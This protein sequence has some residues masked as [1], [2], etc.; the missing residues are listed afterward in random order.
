MIN[1]DLLKCDA[2]E[3]VADFL[4]IVYS[5]N[6][7]PNITSPTRLTSRSHTL[8]HKNFSR[9]INDDC[10][11]GNLVSPISDHHVKFLIIPNYTT[12]QNSKNDFYK[13]NFRHFCFKNFITDLQKVKWDNILN[14][15]VDNVNKS[16]QNI[17]NK[18]TDILDKHASITRLFPKVMES[19]NKSWLTK[20]NLKFI[21]T[22]N[23][24]SKE[25]YHLEFKRYKRM[26][27]KL[28]RINK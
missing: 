27:N 19:S 14:V 21:R 1:I 12:T 24:H 23:L 15:F 26:I 13:Q 3:N 18:I 9:V 2:S 8:I 4:D 7:H 11:A 16:F 17:S 20:E 6:L 22:K 28:M 25:V 10:I 5:T